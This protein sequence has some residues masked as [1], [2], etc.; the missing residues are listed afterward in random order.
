MTGPINGLVSNEGK[1]K[2]KGELDIQWNHKLDTLTDF[3]TENS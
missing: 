2:K 1:E 3:S